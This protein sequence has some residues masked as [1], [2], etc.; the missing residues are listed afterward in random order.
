MNDREE[1]RAPGIGDTQ[2][3]IL[4]ALKRRGRLTLAD[5]GSDVRLT[6]GTLR[7][8]LNALAAH[9]LVRRVGRRQAGRGRPE[10]VYGLTE[11]G[12][13]LFPQREGEL[14][15]ELVRHLLA[16]GDQ[17]ILRAFFDARVGA[18]RDAAL[19][20]LQG[21]TGEARLR[22]VAAILREEG[23]MPELDRSPA[24]GRAIIRLCHCP[25]TDVVA[26][27]RLPCRAE[28]ELVGEMI[29]A[30]LERISYMP[31]GAH[32]CSYAVR[33]AVNGGSAPD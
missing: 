9:G 20:R 14:L 33:E 13:A 11:D 17:E 6:A 24:S 29:G 27:T 31:E 28:L 3:A 12:D 23:F 4:E 30:P 1:F 18:R 8:H 25:L 5:L 26:V 22:E 16:S 19:T 10:V 15:A 7:E 21:L 32:T 2:R